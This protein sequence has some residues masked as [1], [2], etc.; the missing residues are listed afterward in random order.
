[1]LD[2]TLIRP[3]RNGDAE[4]LVAFLSEARFIHGDADFTPKGK[5]VLYFLFSE[6]LDILGL[7]EAEVCATR[8]LRA[9]D[10]SLIV[11]KIALRHGF[12]DEDFVEG[13]LTYL[14]RE[15]SPMD[16]DY[17]YLLG[18]EVPFER[19][20]GFIPCAPNGIYYHE[21]PEKNIPLLRFYPL[22]KDKPV[23]PGFLYR[24]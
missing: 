1:M 12:E 6:R 21:D 2:K 15:C 19:E 11:T 22:D 7:L 14:L 20:I 3:Y 17:V 8:H 18:E 5:H 9:I 23:L 10:P 4:K 13:L 16:V 24:L